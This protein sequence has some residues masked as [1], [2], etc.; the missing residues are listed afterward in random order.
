MGMEEWMVTANSEAVEC[1]KDRSLQI[2]NLLSPWDG[3]GWGVG[4]WYYGICCH[5]I[6]NDMI[7][8]PALL[9]HIHYSSREYNQLL[10]L[11]K[12]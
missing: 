8:C 2:N 9:Q 6:N 3:G 4:D 1:T 11:K 12:N 7:T 5:H 10:Y